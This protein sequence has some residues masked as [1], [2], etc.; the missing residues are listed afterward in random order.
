MFL[1]TIKLLLF[2]FSMSVSGDSELIE[3]FLFDAEATRYVIVNW[4]KENWD[5]LPNEFE[6][7]KWVSWH[8]YVY[9]SSN[10]MHL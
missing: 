1:F 8:Y 5:G 2:L 6:S 7:R 10:S 9:C 3:S 4:Y